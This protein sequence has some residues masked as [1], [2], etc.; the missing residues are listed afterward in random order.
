[1][2]STHQMNQKSKISKNPKSHSHSAKVK[3]L[4]KIIPNH[5]STNWSNQNEIRHV[6]SILKQSIYSNH[7]QHTFTQILSPKLFMLEPRLLMPLLV[8]I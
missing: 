8:I 5:F 4:G 7:A 3:Y 6:I 1:M 2:I